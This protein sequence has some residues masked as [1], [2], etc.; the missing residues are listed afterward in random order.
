MKL[1]QPLAARLAPALLALCA[2]APVQAHN[3]WLM[4]SSTV[5]SKAEWITV[6]AAVS[7]DL[8]YFNHVPLALDNLAVTAPDGSA[9]APQ[10]AHRGKLRSVFDL[11]LKQAGTYRIAVTNGGLSASYKDP[12]TGQTRRWRGTAEKLATEVPAD[13]PELSVMQSAG[14]IETFVTVGKPSVPRPSGQGLELVPVT[15]PN[16]LVKGEQ[17]TFALHLDGQPAPGVE[18]SVVQGGTRYRDKIG[19]TKVTTGAD[20]RFSVT[21]PQAGMYWIETDLRDRKTSVPQAKER[22]LSY[23]LT[24]EVLP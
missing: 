11:E 4:P 18:V 1:P 5:L 16:D 13:A 9:M 12:A 23:V 19:E 6:D 24:V 20:G 8:F 7:N 10:N 14:R 2:A 3:L 21:W 15:H 17:A 22:R